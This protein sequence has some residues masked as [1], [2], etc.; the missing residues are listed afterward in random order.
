LPKII[1]PNIGGRRR[2]IDPLAYLREV[3][4]RLPHMINWQISSI[5]SEV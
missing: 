3:L 1:H 5:T 2:G 4:T